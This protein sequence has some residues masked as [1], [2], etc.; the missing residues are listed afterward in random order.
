MQLHDMQR[1][2]RIQTRTTLARKASRM[3]LAAKTAKKIIEKSIPRTPPASGMETTI[4]AP[5]SALTEMEVVDPATYFP[6]LVTS[7][8]SD[9]ALDSGFFTGGS[10]LEA[11]RRHLQRWNKYETYRSV[12]KLKHDVQKYE[13]SEKKKRRG[14]ED[15]AY[16]IINAFRNP[17]TPS[18][19]KDLRDVL[20]VPD[21]PVATQPTA[22]DTKSG[23]ISWSVQRAPPPNVP[24]KPPESLDKE[25]KDCSQLEDWVLEY[26]GITVRLCGDA[27]HSG[28]LSIHTEKA[29]ASS[30]PG[31]HAGRSEI[32]RRTK[33]ARKGRTT[34]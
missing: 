33:M 16:R 17:T 23:P 21:Q 29:Q 8:R 26:T 13:Q 24:V 32:G 18:T 1:W 11:R 31:I 25:H 34:R 14:Y 27:G 22:E 3:S 10:E 6:D 5:D 2:K 20:P 30:K 7:T 4:P 19:V 28:N 15:E 12:S 9:P